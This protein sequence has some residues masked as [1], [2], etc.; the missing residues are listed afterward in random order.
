MGLQVAG[1]VQ[2]GREQQAA[3]KYNAKMQQM[4]AL[5]AERRGSMAE[6]RAR[7]RAAWILGKQHAEQGGS[8]LVAGADSGG[9]ILAQT[10][11]FGAEDAAMARLN[12][13]REAWGFRTGAQN[14]R[15]E[16][17]QAR[18]ANNARIGS[19][20]LTGTTNAF[21]RSPWWKSLQDDDQEVAPGS[22][23]YGSSRSYWGY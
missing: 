21:S 11:E 16:A 17:Q 13:A 10:A 6:G 1:Q 23:G 8:G 20:F 5:D 14:T 9:D 12:G 19:T 15:F 18:S 3:Y 4:Q 22:L 2:Q 7:Q